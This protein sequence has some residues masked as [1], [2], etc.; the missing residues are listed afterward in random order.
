[1]TTSCCLFSVV[2]A[3]FSVLRIPGGELDVR[4]RGF[5]TVVFLL[6]WCFSASSAE[7]VVTAAS[8]PWPPFTDPDHPN[9]GLSLEVVRAALGT[10]G[11]EVTMRFVPWA[12]AE[13]GAR[14][15]VYDI[16]PNAWMTAERERIFFFSEPYVEN[17]IVF[18]RRKG[19]PFKYDGLE[20]LKGFVVGVIRGY[21]YEESFLQ[22]SGF[23]REE[24]SDFLTNIRK[25]LAGRIDMTLEDEMVARR[26]LAEGGGEYAEKIEF[27][28]EPLVV[29]NLYVVCGLS[30]PRHR[31]IIEAFN[32]GLRSIRADGTYDKIMFSYGFP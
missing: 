12:R 27:V 24:A 8:D 32:G 6:F 31:E 10:E 23:V 11:Y 13:E 22:A 26:L 9:Q 2:F 7:R 16:V 28:A 1:M 3:G 19:E 20:S 15:G 17:R 14:Q 30:N 18:I 5:V 4:R 25:L 29:K 21:G